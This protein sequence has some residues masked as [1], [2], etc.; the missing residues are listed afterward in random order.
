MPERFDFPV[1]IVDDDPELNDVIRSA[2]ADVGL[3]EVRIS[4]SR[5][6]AQK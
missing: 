6:E 3:G 4:A 5:G 1:L 2:V